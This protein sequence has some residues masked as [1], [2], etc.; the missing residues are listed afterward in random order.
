[1]VSR[2]ILAPLACLLFMASCSSSKF[3]SD[4]EYCY[5]ERRYTESGAFSF[6]GGEHIESTADVAYIFKQLEDKS[7][8]NSF[9]CMVKDGVPTVIHLGIGSSVAVMAPLENAFVAFA[10][11]KPDK[12]WFIHNHPSGKLSV[13]REDA[14]LQRRMEKIFG[15]A[16]QPG[17]IIN[18]TSGKFMTYSEQ[19]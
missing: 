11:L 19:F 15:V 5:V 1:M 7:V 12:I 8:E 9:I 4:G 13:S 17:I 2:R 14:M 6:V 3:L 18:T 10:E 16:A